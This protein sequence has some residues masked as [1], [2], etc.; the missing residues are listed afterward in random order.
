MV[1][2]HSIRLFAHGIGLALVCMVPFQWLVAFIAPLIMMDWMNVWTFTNIQFT[3]A[4]LT[5]AAHLVGFI[6]LSQQRACLAFAVLVPIVPLFILLVC[7][8]RFGLTLSTLSPHC[9]TFYCRG[10]TLTLTAR[11]ADLTFPTACSGF[12]FIVRLYLRAP[13]HCVLC[14]AFIALF[15]DNAFL[16]F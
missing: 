5:G 1:Y 15:L 16:A 2:Q 12:V 9:A 4:A 8:V 3:F 7:L 6:H 11:I 13:L 14:R 10:A